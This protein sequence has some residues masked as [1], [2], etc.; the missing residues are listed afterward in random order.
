M[1]GTPNMTYKF[2]NAIIRKPNKSIQNALSSQYLNPS[3][4]KVLEIHKNYISSLEEAGLNIA[5]LNSLEQ[6]PDSIFVE[7]PAIIYKKNIIILNLSLIHI[8][9]PTRP[10]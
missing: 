2:T 6:Y 1:P 3:Y 9:E 4:E 7:D 8:S 10:Y 5:I